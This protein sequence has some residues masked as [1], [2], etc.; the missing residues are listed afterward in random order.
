MKKKTLKCRPMVKTRDIGVMDDESTCLKLWGPAWSISLSISKELIYSFYWNF[1]QRDARSIQRSIPPLASGLSTN[2]CTHTYTSFPCHPSSS[3]YKYIS[4]YIVFTL[5]WLSK[6][7]YSLRYD[8]LTF[9]IHFVSVF[10]WFICLVFSVLIINSTLNSI[11]DMW[12]SCEETHQLSYQFSS[13]WRT[14][15]LSLLTYS[16]L[17]WWLSR[18]VVQ[19]SYWDFS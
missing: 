17:D 5:F 14:L 12:V 8:G 15:S 1:L 10:V 11:P 16:A 6:C 7:N 3:Q 9:P 19:L 18:P 4:V 2:I 13:S